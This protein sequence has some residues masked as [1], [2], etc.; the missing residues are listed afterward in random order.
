MPRQLLSSLPLLACLCF[1]PVFAGPTIDLS[2][3]AS[4]PAANDLVKAVVYAEANGSDPAELARRINHDIAEA[5][6]LIKS[7]AGV[8][9]KSGNQQTYPVYGN[10]RRIETWR[11]R[12]E[13]MLESKDVAALSDL[14]GRLQ[15][16]KLALGNVSQSPSDSTRREVE[17]AATRE[18][19]KAFERRA[20]VIAST[21]G[22]AYRIKQMS[23]QQA[24]SYPPVMPMRAA[25][26]MMVA[27][28]APAP[29]EAGESTL[30]VS[31]SGQI[32]LAD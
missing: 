30:T 27:D 1:S 25:R 9:V 26:A 8:T 2:A 4:L 3:E 21:L 13:L 19:I 5:L 22:K 24:G 6:R 11:M 23:I 12:S 32:E 7:K 10:N 16:M 17:E 18:A 31:I 14:L 29:V 28:A 15:Q 20:G